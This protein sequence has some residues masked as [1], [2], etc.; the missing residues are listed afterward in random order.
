MALRCSAGIS[1]LMVGLSPER[2][3]ASIRKPVIGSIFERQLIVMLVSFTSL[4]RVRRGGLMSVEPIRDKLI[5]AF[6]KPIIVLPQRK[7]ASLVR[8]PVLPGI[9]LI[10]PYKNTSTQTMLNCCRSTQ[11]SVYLVHVLCVKFNV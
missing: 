8:E 10:G 5:V 7:D 9:L 6:S 11:H 3:L 1:F 2:G 4:M